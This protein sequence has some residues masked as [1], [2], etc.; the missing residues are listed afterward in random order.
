MPIGLTQLGCGFVATI[1]LG[2]CC[3]A[4]DLPRIEVRETAGIQR[5]GYPVAAEFRAP[6]ATKPESFRLRDA[7]RWPTAPALTYTHD[8]VV[9]R[10]RNPIDTSPTSVN[11]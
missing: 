11:P 1:L 2:A 7:E 9:V 4:A 3:L 10:L 5:F 6:A 8:H